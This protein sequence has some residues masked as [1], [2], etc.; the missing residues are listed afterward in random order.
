MFAPLF[1][2]CS[3]SSKTKTPAPSPMTNPS[4]LVSQGRDALEGS[5]FLW[6]SALHATKPP[7]PIG[8]IAE[9]EPP[10]SI[11]SASPLMIW[12]AAFN[13]Q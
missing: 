2:A 6:E 1:L 11:T 4:R 13:I 9:S 12:F 3:N 5:V 7:K 10:Q 8:I